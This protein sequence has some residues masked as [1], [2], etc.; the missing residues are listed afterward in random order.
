[1]MALWLLCPVCLRAHAIIVAAVRAEGA[2]EKLV[3]AY[4]ILS[5]MDKGDELKT[6]IDYLVDN[7]IVDGIGWG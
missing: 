2:Y 4:E 7:G 3:E 6:A 1:M 5:P